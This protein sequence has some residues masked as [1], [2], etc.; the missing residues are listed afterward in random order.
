MPAGG[1]NTAFVL[2]RLSWHGYL[3]LLRSALYLRHARNQ[4]AL[5]VR[6]VSATANR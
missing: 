4:R 1:Y 3:F 5:L 6:S 2:N